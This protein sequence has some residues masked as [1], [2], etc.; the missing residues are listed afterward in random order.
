[1]IDPEEIQ[2]AA[3]AFVSK[4]PKPEKSTLNIVSQIC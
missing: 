2:N 3:E 1:M 4:V